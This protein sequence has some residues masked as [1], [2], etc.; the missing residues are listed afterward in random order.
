VKVRQPLST[1]YVVVPS[2]QAADL[3]GLEGIVAEELNVRSIVRAHG[4]DELVDYSVKPNFKALGPRFGSRMGELAGAISSVDPAELV[5]QIENHGVAALNVGGEEVSL[6]HDDLD[7]RVQGREGFAL[8]QDGPF[9]VALDVELTEELIAEGVAREVIRGV[10]EL[11]KSSGLAVEDRIQLWLA[12]SDDVSS[13]VTRH[14]ELIA[15]EVLSL[16]TRVG[17]GLGEDTFTTVIDV[18]GGTVSAALARA[19]S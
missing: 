10:Q 19:S 9:G 8:I 5:H 3:E 6:H 4:L 15:R 13:A 17:E 1:A 16:S 2:A 12:P 14:E 7:I 18:E 11:R